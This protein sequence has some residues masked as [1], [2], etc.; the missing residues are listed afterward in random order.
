MIQLGLKYQGRRATRRF[1]RENG[2]LRL[3]TEAVNRGNSDNLTFRDFRSRGGYG[4]S[5]LPESWRGVGAG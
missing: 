3:V 1:R 4:I 5:R 2:N